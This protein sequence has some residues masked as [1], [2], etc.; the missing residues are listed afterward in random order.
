MGSGIALATGTWVM[1]ASPPARSPVGIE[2]ADIPSPVV[3]KPP[4]PT[5]ATVDFLASAVVFA[6]A[7]LHTEVMPQSPQTKPASTI[8]S[9][10]VK[11]D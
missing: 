2:P 1:R 10:L 4:V 6:S 9:A 5:G 3:A 8:A 7:A 11:S